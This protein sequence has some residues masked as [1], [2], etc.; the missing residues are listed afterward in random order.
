M[1][2]IPGCDTLSPMSYEVCLVAMQKKFSGVIGSGQCVAFV[3]KAAKA[4]PTDQW[5]KGKKVAGDRTVPAGT[6][7]ATF[8]PSGIYGNHTDGRSHAAIYISQDVTG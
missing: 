2:N 6:A 4:P 3:Q 8:D 5:R 1:D 7:I